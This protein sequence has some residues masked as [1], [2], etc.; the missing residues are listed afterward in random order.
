MKQLCAKVKQRW[1]DAYIADYSDVTGRRVCS[2]I[3]TTSDRTPYYVLSKE[4]E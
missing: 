1:Q 3:L 4:H 2:L